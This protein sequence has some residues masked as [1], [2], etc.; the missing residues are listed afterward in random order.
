M[1]EYILCSVMESPMMARRSPGC[2]S[3]PAG[4]GAFT[5][6]NVS[7]KGSLGLNSSSAADKLS[8]VNVEKGT[9]SKARRWS[10]GNDI[11][12]L[13]D[14]ELQSEHPS[15]DE[16]L[17]AGDCAIECGGQFHGVAQCGACA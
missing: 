15:S 3:R 17:F 6:A 12:M 11:F 10:F 7:K 14:F 4:A 13:I 16:W 5:G 8:A 9:A 1:R 2:S